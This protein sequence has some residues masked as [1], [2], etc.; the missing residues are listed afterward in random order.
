MLL[1]ISSQYASAIHPELH[2]GFVVGFVGP[3]P[4]VGFVA[5]VVVCGQVVP[6]PLPFGS[7]HAH[8]E[9][10]DVTTLHPQQS[11]PS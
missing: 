1:L 10:Y 11:P 6:P 3:V 2:P 5:P 8:T 4:V 9:Q 7:R